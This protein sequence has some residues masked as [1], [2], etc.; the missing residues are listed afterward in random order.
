MGGRAVR[1]V[2][3]GGRACILNRIRNNANRGSSLIRNNMEAVETVGVRDQPWI[4]V[5]DHK[6]IE[7][8][9]ER[10]RDKF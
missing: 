6:A 7:N 5:G 1:R 3:A 9:I 2:I 8:F 4:A 10:S